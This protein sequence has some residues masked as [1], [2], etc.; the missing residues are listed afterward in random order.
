MLRL[1]PCPKA[2]DPR[3]RTAAG[4]LRHLVQATVLDWRGALRTGTLVGPRRLRRLALDRAAAR[5]DLDLMRALVAQGCDPAEPAR[6]GLTPAVPEPGSGK[7][8]RPGIGG[9][10][11][12]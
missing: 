12:A 9:T 11:R 3:L 4:K 7:G 2:G 5:D 8:V 1:R 10:D 6:N